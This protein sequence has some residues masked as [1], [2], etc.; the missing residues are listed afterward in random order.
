MRVDVVGGKDYTTDEALQLAQLLMGN[1]YFGITVKNGESTLVVQQY[2]T[3][4]LPENPVRFQDLFGKPLIVTGKIWR[5]IKGF[6]QRVYRAVKKVLPIVAKVATVAGAV[7]PPPAGTIIMAVGKGITTATTAINAIAAG[8]Q[9][10]GVLALG[11][12]VDYEQDV[13]TLTYESAI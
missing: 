6:F 13:F 10:Q 5:R 2:G 12:V 7:I 3:F 8:F 9:K 11:E 4:N 1:I